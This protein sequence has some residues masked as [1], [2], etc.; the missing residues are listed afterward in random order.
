[1]DKDYGGFFWLV[2]RNG[3]PIQDHKQNYGQ[4]FAIY[5]L[6]EY[7]RATNELESLN[8]AQALFQLMEKHTYD[9]GDNVYIEATT[10][11]WEKLDYNRL[12]END[13]ASDK[14]MNTMLH[15]LEA[16][17][18]LLRVWDDTQIHTQIH[19]IIE[20]FQC[21]IIDHK[22]GHFKCYFD[23]Q[24]H[25][26][27]DNIS[28]GHD[29]EGSWLSVEAATLLSDAQSAA[30]VCKSCLK[31]AEVV[32]QQSRD[33]DGSIFYEGDPGRLTDTNKANRFF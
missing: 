6:S 1:L 26:L 17:T 11:E 2:D 9:K 29:I 14:S 23:K 3:K 19:S 22:T 33:K 8:L 20:T 18:N 32:Y 15:I 13:M 27:S 7:Y 25:S 30:Q 31:M 4:A 21:F 10:R 24:W 12:S 5:A 28:F 16:Y